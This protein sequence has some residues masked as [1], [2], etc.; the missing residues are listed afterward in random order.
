[1]FCFTLRPAGLL[2]LA[3]ALVLHFQVQ[4]DFTFGLEQRTLVF[5][6]LS[7]R[8]ADR[9]FPSDIGA[10]WRADTAWLASSVHLASLSRSTVH[11]VTRFWSGRDIKFIKMIGNTIMRRADNV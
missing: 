1:M 3:F 5:V 11:V 4:M 10:V 9:S 6:C 8:P 2:T 7:I